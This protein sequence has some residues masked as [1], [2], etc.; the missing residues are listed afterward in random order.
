MRIDKHASAVIDRIEIYHA[1]ALLDT[2]SGCNVLYSALLDTSVSPIDLVTTHACL[3]HDTD[4]EEFRA[5]LTSVNAAPSTI[6]SYI[7]T[8][9]VILC[10]GRRARAHL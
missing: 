2:V 4:P 10:A 1:G 6:T 7:D 5:W 9:T 3:L 8:N